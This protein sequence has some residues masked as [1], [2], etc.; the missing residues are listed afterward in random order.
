M[1]CVQNTI[2]PLGQATMSSKLG[3]LMICSAWMLSASLTVVGASETSMWS[4][5][6]DAN[7]YNAKR[8]EFPV[9]YS[10]L[11]AYITAA[12]SN[13][14]YSALVDEYARRIAKSSRWILLQE[15]NIEAS[16][17]SA[18]LLY[19]PADERTWHAVAFGVVGGSPFR[20]KIRTVRNQQLIEALSQ[21]VQSREDIDFSASK[22]LDGTAA[23]IT[24]YSQGALNRMAVY[25]PLSSKS[26]S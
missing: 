9:D 6:A 4:L 3:L 10:V 12:A 16:S 20:N 15:I 2:F 26:N 14:K 17:Y 8:A 21:E 24:S 23:F 22:V 18:A 7:Y 5:N 11:P 25:E 19:M 1:L 13:E